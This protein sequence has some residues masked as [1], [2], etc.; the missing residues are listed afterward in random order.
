MRK[1]K[2]LLAAFAAMVSLGASA[3]L[4]NGTVYWIQDVATNQF[5]SQGANWGTQATVQDVGGV[6]F[7]AVYVSDGVYKLKNIMWN[8]VNNADLGLRVTDG[9]CD[10]AASEVT[11]TASGDGYLVGIAGGNYLCNNQA[12]NSYGV[13]PIG[14]STEQA[15]ATVWRFLT[16]DEYDAAIRAYKD[17]KAAA[18][19]SALGYTATSVSGLEA[20]FAENFIAKDYTSSITNAALNAGNTNGWTAIKPNQRNQ[21]FGS[22]NG[23]CA[24]SWNGCVV[25]SQ[26][27]NGLPNGLYKVSFVG[28]FRPKG[29]T[30][31]QKLSSEQTS[32]PAYVF[33]ND[34]KEEF[35]HW[36]DVAAKANNRTDIKNNAAAYTSTFYTYVTDG[37]LKLGVKQD[38]WYN[39]N[40]WCPFG[41]FTLTYYSDQVSADEASSL[42]ASVPT[43]K[44]NADVQTTLNTAKSNF[45]ANQSIANYNALQAAIESANTSI[46]NYAAVKVYLDNAESLD[47]SGQSTFYADQTAAAVK[48]GYENGSLVALTPEQITTLDAAILI[49][50]KAQTT[51]GAN[52]TLAIVNPSFE[53]G[54][55][56]WTNSGMAT[57]LNTSFALKVGSYYAETWQ[58]NGTKS[59]KQ[60]LTGM[61]SGVYRLSANVL[62]RGVTSAKIFANDINKAATIGETANTYTVEFA[63]D[64]NADVE[65]G[66]E[67]AGTGAANSWLCVD[68]FTLTYVGGLPD[69]TAVE[70]KMNAEVA[71][72]QANAVNAYNT[73]KTVANYNAVVA[74]I[75]AAEASVAAYSKAAQAISDAKALKDAH[76]FASSAATATFA[77]A[78]ATIENSYTEGTLSDDAANNAATT[79]GVA[80]TGWHAGNNN[81]AVVYMRDGF[82]LG[83]FDVDLHV[84]S[85][86]TEGANDGSNFVVPFYEYWTDN[87]NKLAEKTWTG[88]VTGLENGLYKVSVWTRVQA[89]NVEGASAASATGITID[90][91]GGTAIDVTNGEQIGESLFQLNSYEAEGL[92]KDGKLSLNINVAANNNISWLS[93]KN[94]KYT[95]KRDLTPEESFVYPTSITLDKTT[96]TM[97]TG[98]TLTLV[99]TV[100]PEDADDKTVSW[101]SSNE[102]VATIS[103]GVISAV[104][105]G[106]AT[107]TA[108]ATRGEN[109]TT[110]MTVTVTDVAA[111]AYYSEIA[112]GEFYI[113]N[114]GTGKF[115]GG[116]NN[117]GTH[118][119]L[120]E[121]GIPFTITGE[122]GVYTFDSHTYN[123]ASKHFF[124]G[125]YVD[126]ATTN[127]YVT[128][129]GNGRYSISTAEGAS[130]VSGWAGNSYV[131]NEAT[132]ANASL[133]QWY[134]L[135]KNDRDKLLV[136]ATAEN[137]VDATYY[138]KEA[139]ISRNLRESYNK[140]GWTGDKAY[141]GAE[142]N[143]CAE[144]YHAATN[145]YQ[146]ITV[147]NGTYTLKAQ[148]FYR[149]DEGSADASYLYAN[150]QQVALAVFNAN[151][152]E[153]VAS[154][155]GASAAFTAGQYQNELTV[156]VTDR[157]LT[158]G[159]K[160]DDTNNWTIWDNFEL[161]MTSYTP[162]TGVTAEIDNAEL[163]IDG[164]ATITAAT[165]PANAS[166]NALTY[167]SSNEAV[168]TVDADGKVTATGIGSATITIAA[169]EM[170]SFSTTINVTVPANYEMVEGEMNA[171]IAAAQ[172]AAENAFKAEGGNTTENYRA[173]LSAIAAA[174]AS[175]N[176]YAKLGAA[177]TKID[178]ALAAATTATASTADYVAVKTAY[179]E[180]TIADADIMTN[181]AAAYNA[182]IPV[183]KSQTAAQADFTLAIQNQS[184]E[185]GDMTGW[186]AVSSSDTG[187]RE[188]SNATYAAA[189]S[190][191]YYLFNT[192]WQGVPVS[193][194]ISD[195]PNGE[196]TLTASVASDGATVYLVANGEHNDGT[197]TYAETKIEE[198][199]YGKDT[200]QDAT[201]TF[202]VKQGSVTIAAVGGADGDA[203]VHKDYVEEGYWWYKA[204]NFRLVKNRNLTS[205]EEFVAATD[206]DY[207]LLNGNLDKYALGFEAGEFAPY[208]NLTLVQAIAAA[209]AID[210][211][212]VNSQE[213]VQ[214]AAE[215]ITSAGG[216][217]NETEV[218]A[219]YDGTFAVAAANG[220][221]AGWTMSNNTLGGDYHSRV[222]N[223][224]E[225]LSE[226][227]ETNSALFI[228]FDGTNSDRGSQYFYGNTEGYTMPLKANTY[229][230]ITVDFAG[231]G[232][233]GKTLRMNLK[234]PDGFA[235]SQEYKHEHK[236]D[237]ES[238]YTPQQFNIVF[239]TGNTEGNYVIGFQCPGNDNN[240]HNAVISNLRLFTEPESSATLAVTD[241]KY[242]TFIAPFAVEIPNGVTAYTIESSNGNEL[243]LTEVESD[244][245]AANTPVV[246]FSENEVNEVFNGYSLAIKDSYTVGWLTGTYE[247]IDAPDGKYIMQKQNDKVG[248]YHVDYNYLAQ[249]GMDKPKVRAN[250][251]YLTAPADAAGARAFF[252]DGGE[253]TGI[254]AIEALANG[255]AQIFNVNGVQQ[256]RLTKGLNIIVTKDGKTHKVMVK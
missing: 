63:C 143:Q 184:F 135:S 137:P 130:F 220:A 213:S 219:V 242:G 218:N 200:F 101:S 194:T 92:V 245:I 164:T 216:I 90:V 106:T 233:T 62:A 66:F 55:T 114:A 197:E 69:V 177:I 196:Y 82:G 12:E 150:D 44:M 251:A 98:E 103:N 185:Y 115:L 111:P 110:S 217:A 125:T 142:G 72:T 199:Q 50:A 56:G 155:A 33:A 149:A 201:I 193:Q 176:A 31:S 85:W 156:T 32:S 209:K 52:M 48:T 138:I 180:G 129:L 248:F 243:V 146:T 206:A 252:F 222:F 132:S 26:E 60:T 244:D 97:T 1:L 3:Q 254:S 25:A 57:Q 145:V 49:A 250:R 119:S 168:A 151:G 30:E 232:S 22:E 166:F 221:P 237:T 91:N 205:E 189:G 39:G 169:N 122:N 179:N 68:N 223:G 34:A 36:I 42:I 7:E 116:A 207:A 256:S 253:T 20:L 191:G 225:R 80:V 170:E 96:A 75:S 210:Q 124:S 160:T 99:A 128:S 54:F 64:D 241:A 94:V 51:E 171:E 188:T 133:A 121:H 73:E 112:A 40:T 45:E 236:A 214:A 18:Y 204:D 21:A 255:D 239:Q 28:T 78:I 4:E 105:A 47:E 159:V 230:R 127:L 117:Y 235:K 41:Y 190:D 192:W 27:V 107:I 79:L 118:A 152:E 38:T 203:G 61:P 77:D 246:V 2:L 202:L 5:L 37:T 17:R 71:T 16:K 102:A 240:K 148:G 231:W 126:G 88:T 84:N 195:L 139:N 86:S 87:K 123:D 227:N 153:T 43:G 167:S 182:V 81:A 76:N 249:E 161:L 162:N 247:D 178:A 89:Q 186:S 157:T 6:G 136:N 8:K 134:F 15:D 113:V 215:A 198:E 224:D 154:M 29:S 14:L 175:K 93:F 9:Y 95:K 181:V 238:G 147:P 59:V 108:T 58:P 120:I 212:A 104:G 83:E 11:L 172:A 67:G 211:T 226:F 183:I 74:A 165:V 53:N 163:A 141:G 174:Q 70:G 228:R 35:I 140:S 234:G 13:K 10:Q 187:V 173:L 131:S 24:E 109:V 23:T 144:R 158:L 65:I 100:L 46:A 208:N 19:A 229:Y